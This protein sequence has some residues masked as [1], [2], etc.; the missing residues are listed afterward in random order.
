[1]TT[2]A[3]KSTD[4]LSTH[5]A[6]SRDDWITTRQAPA[7]IAQGKV[8]YNYDVSPITIDELTPAGSIAIRPVLSSTA[9]GFAPELASGSV[10]CTTTLIPYR[11]VA[12]RR[13]RDIT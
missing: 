8:C 11:R 5:P 7:E 6:V 12:T 4:D 13:D 1:M 10:A 3:Q 9:I 2:E